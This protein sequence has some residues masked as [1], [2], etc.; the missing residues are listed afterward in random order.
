VRNQLLACAK[1]TN[2]PCPILATSFGRK[3]GKPRIQRLFLIASVLQKIEASCPKLEV[4]D[5]P[6]VLCRSVSSVRFTVRHT[7]ANPKQCHPERSEGSAF[8]LG[9]P[10]SAILP[11]RPPFGHDGGPRLIPLLQRALILSTAKDLRSLLGNCGV[12]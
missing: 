1:K 4:G 9:D 11:H 8:V 6:N 5:N 7:S 10:K 2:A 3:G 12:A